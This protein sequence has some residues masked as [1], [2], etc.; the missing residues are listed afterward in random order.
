MIFKNIKKLAT[1]FSANTPTGFGQNAMWSIG[2][3]RISLLVR[4]KKIEETLLGE[5]SWGT[6]AMP[7]IGMSAT[8]FRGFVV[9]H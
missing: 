6:D 7:Q 4:N 9:V 5:M 8:I 3:Q 2:C 1:F